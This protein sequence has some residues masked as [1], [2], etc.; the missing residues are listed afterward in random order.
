MKISESAVALTGQRSYSKYQETRVESVTMRASAWNELQEISGNQSAEM[1]I[2][3]ESQSL[4]DKLSEQKQQEQEAKQKNANVQNGPNDVAFATSVGRPEEDQMIQVLRRILEMLKQ[5]RTGKQPIHHSGNIQKLMSEDDYFSNSVQRSGQS[6][7]LSQ[8][9][10]MVDFR[11]SSASMS[12]SDSVSGGTPVTGGSTAWVR[13]V[14]KNGFVL[15]QETTTFSAT[16]V[17]KT[18]D[19]RDISFGVDLEM[20]RGFA[21]A[22]FES[23]TE[24][25]VLTDPLVINLGSETASVSNQKF[26]FDLDADGKE[27][28]ISALGQGSGFLSY[29][30][31]GDGVINDGSELFGTKSGDGFADLAKYDEDGN[32][33]IDENDQIFKD[34]KVWTRDAEGRDKLVDLKSAD[35]GAIYLGSASTQFHLNDMSNTTNA[36][37]QKTGVFLRESGSVGTVQ[38]L[39]LV[40]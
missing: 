38:H 37:V 3:V 5:I 29:D 23:C 27:E 6:F 34:L 18:A 33:W 32:G 13:H 14:E 30:K 39:D 36:V 40:V 25:V 11:S 4:L 15:E 24:D 10:S 2:S 8:W 16:G 35:V 9:V 26:F 7:R 31:N 1:T 19:G 12:A 21:G 28:E 17:A 22:F 20:S